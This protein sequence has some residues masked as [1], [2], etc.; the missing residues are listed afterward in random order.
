MT[1]LVPE[2]GVGNDVWPS[3]VDVSEASVVA[4]ALTSWQK[5]NPH[6]KKNKTCGRKNNLTMGQK[7]R[8][9]TKEKPH[10]KKYCMRKMNFEGKP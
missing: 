1:S 7:E 9:T 6:G 2:V 5:E 4:K 10:S 8:L 3:D